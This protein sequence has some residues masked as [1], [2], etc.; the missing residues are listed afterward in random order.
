MEKEEIV[1]KIRE[2]YAAFTS[3]VKGT[4]EA[5][6]M[7]SLNAEK[8]TAG[9]QL[10]HLCMSVAP[11]LKGLKA[12]EFALKAMFGKADHSSLSY[13][14]LVAKY[15]AGLAAGGTA[16]S[17]FRPAAIAFARKGELIASL[18]ELVDKLCTSVEKFSEEKLDTLVLPHPLIGKLT[19]REMLYFTIYHA[20]HHHKHC[21][22]NLEAR[23]EAAGT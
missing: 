22:A 18:N 8:W 19:I 21:V 11:L 2:N 13:D 4:S 5:D 10:E 17:D 6:F 20:E 16:P 3:F 9:Q 12:P 1:G 7:F 15:Q 14:E 23:T